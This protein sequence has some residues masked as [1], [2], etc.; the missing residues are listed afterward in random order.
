MKI[1][2]KYNGEPKR[3]YNVAQ[4]IAYGKEGVYRNILYP[5][6]NHDAVL[7]IDYNGNKRLIRADGREM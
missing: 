5:D 3:T 6:T 7:V 4:L 2:I 1:D